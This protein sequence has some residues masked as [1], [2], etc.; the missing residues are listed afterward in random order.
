MSWSAPTGRDAGDVIALFRVGDPNA[1]YL[2]VSSTRG[3]TTGTLTLPA[4]TQ[5]GQYEFRYLVEEA[6]TTARSGVITVS[7][8]QRPDPRYAQLRRSTKRTWLENPAAWAW[9]RLAP[10]A[11]VH[12]GAGHAMRAVTSRPSPLDPQART[13]RL[14]LSLEPRRYRPSPKAPHH[15]RSRRAESVRTRCLTRRS[16]SSRYRRQLVIMPAISRNRL[17]R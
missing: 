12:D 13:R 2:W 16:P 1:D 17:D 6:A 3:T 9:A 7:A 10:A 15:T 5:P 8:D 14:T 4:P 11:P